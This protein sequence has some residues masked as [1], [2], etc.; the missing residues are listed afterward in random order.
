MIETL[1]ELIK[2][3]I[4][5]VLGLLFIYTAVRLAVHDYFRTKLSYETKRQPTRNRTPERA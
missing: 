4:Y 5:Y 1:Q 3:G 2:L